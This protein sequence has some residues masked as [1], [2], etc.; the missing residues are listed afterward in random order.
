MAVATRISNNLAKAMADQVTA[1][2]VAGDSAPV[3]QIWNGTQAA[4][5]DTAVADDDTPYSLLAEIT[6]NDPPFPAAADANPG[7]RITA[8]VDPAIAD[9]SA[10]K[11]GTAAWFRVCSVNTGVKTPVIDGSIGTSN[12]D[13]IVPTTTVVATQPFSITS[14][15]V[16]MPET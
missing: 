1:A 15:T 6:L 7:G 2:L 14:W 5:P 12:A 8:D 16:T 4:G 9:S 3:L 11:S 13:M 10:N